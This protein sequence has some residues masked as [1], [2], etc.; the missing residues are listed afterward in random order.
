MLRIIKRSRRV[1]RMHSQQSQYHGWMV[2]ASVLVKLA[3]GRL[4]STRSRADTR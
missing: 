4:V 3:R 2:Y 1:T